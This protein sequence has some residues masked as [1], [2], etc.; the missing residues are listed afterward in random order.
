MCTDFKFQEVNAE[1][2]GDPVVP[3]EEVGPV[4]YEDE[5]NMSA[6]QRAFVNQQAAAMNAVLFYG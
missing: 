6:E 3:L 4:P 5:P 2:S 1:W